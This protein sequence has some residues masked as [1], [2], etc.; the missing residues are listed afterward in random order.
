MAYSEQA[1]MQASDILQERRRKFAERTERRRAELFASIPGLRERETQINEFGIA[2]LR[3]SLSGSS[4]DNDNL[5]LKISDLRESQR[6]LLREC[7]VDENALDPSFFCVKCCDSGVD[8]DGNLCECV[9]AL[10]CRASLDEINRVS[11]LELSSFETFS[12]DYY[13]E[14]FDPE[15]GVSPRD[16]AKRNLNACVA[17]ARAFPRVSKNLLMLGDAGL[18]K[19]HLA[20]SIANEVLHHGFDVVYCSSASVLKQ[21]EAEHFER[22]RANSTLDSLKRCELLVLDD[23]GAEF[24]G[25]FVVS[26][27]YDLINTRL[28]EKRPTVYTTNLLDSSS[29]TRRYGEKICSRLV[30]CCT[31][32][33]FFGD[34]IRIIKN[35]RE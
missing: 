11:P 21:I 25:P 34:D 2:S 26:A 5:N 13:A 18:G 4:T 17:F 6:E 7:G 35:N 12:L 8:S 20:L 3:L 27:L 30:G 33:P 32:L 15:Y 23:L 19:T 1:R 9:K 10:L 28:I 14:A 24:N 29:L 31:V 22:G 16:N